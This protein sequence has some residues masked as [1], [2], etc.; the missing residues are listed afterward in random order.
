[1]DEREMTTVAG[2]VE[3]GSGLGD[4][5]ADDRE[6]AALR[7][8]AAKLVVRQ[9]DRARLVRALGVFQRAALQGDGAGLITARPCEAA[10]QPPQ[11][12]E[13]AR[14]NCFAERVRRTS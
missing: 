6:G 2:C 9:A 3:R 10:V 5:L 1:M 7:V 14:G 12:R 8:A 11:R 4:V 13:A